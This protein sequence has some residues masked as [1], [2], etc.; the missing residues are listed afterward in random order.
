MPSTFY[1]LSLFLIFVRI[2]AVLMTA[3]IFSSR[4]VPSLAKIG[5][6][7]LLALTLAPMPADR[8][9]LG[10]G[11]S[12]LITGQPL[13]A[14]SQPLR[15]ASQPLWAASQVGS[16]LSTWPGGLLAFLLIIAQ[17]VIVGVL[18]GFVSNLVFVAVGMA[19][20][21]MGLQIGFRAANLFDPFTT[22]SS[23]ALEQFYTLLAVALFL[24]I[25]GHHWLIRALART[26]DVAPLG[27]FALS[28]VTIERLV[29]LTG[30]TFVAATRIA[31]PV[32]G[33]LLLADLGLGLVARA[34]PQIQVFFLGMPLKMGLGILALALTLVL[35]LPLVKELLGDAVGNSIA[36]I[37]R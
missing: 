10:N 2:L 14:A 34:V 1:L 30:E 11:S 24:T 31:L 22:A 13:W 21:M 16:S 37:A 17:E 8:S 9:P 26:F 27:T 18:V 35:T 19:A 33:A 5:F 7:G 28:S 32:M 6:A 20:S 29:A 36:I 23:S 25:N 3:P 4:S 15:A 12:F